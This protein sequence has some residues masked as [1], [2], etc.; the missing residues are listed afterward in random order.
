MKARKLTRNRWIIYLLVVMLTVSSINLLPYSMAFA[1]G[2]NESPPESQTT[3]QIEENRV[4]IPTLRTETAK[5]FGNPDGTYTAEVMAKPI[6]FKKGD[7]WEEISNT[8]VPTPDGSEIENKQNKFKVKFPKNIKTPGYTKLFTYEISGR[9]IAFGFNDTPKNEK[10]KV[11]TDKQ[12][13]TINNTKHSVLYKNV[14]K[15][16]S[17]EYKVDGSKVK[18]NII[19]NSYQGKNSFEFYIKAK[20]IKAEKKENGQIVFSDETTGEFLFFIERPF[21]FDS[22]GENSS[23]GAVSQNVS[24]DISTADGGFILT[25]VADDS[26]L[27]DPK[28]VYPVTIDP[29]VDVFQAEDTWIASGTNYNNHYTDYLFIGNHTEFGKTRSLLKWVL[30]TIPNAEV[31]DAQIGLSQY[32]SKGETAVNLHRITSSYDTTKV[33]WATQPSYSPALESSMSIF[34]SNGW[35]EYV[36]ATNLVKGWY[37][38]SFPNYGVLMK[39]GDSQEGTV[40]RKE[41]RATEWINPDG[42]N[43]ENPKLVITYRPKELLGM[44]DYWKYTPDLFEGEGTAVVNVINGNMVYDIGLLSLTSKSNSFDLELVYNSR[45]NYQDSFGYGWSFSDQRRLIIPA[46]KKIVE[47]IDENG[48][49]YHFNKHQDDD[50]TSYSAPEGVYLEFTSTNDGGYTIKQTDETILTFDSLGRNMKITDEKGNNTIYGF[51]GNSNRVVKISERFGTQP[52]GRDLSLSYNS[53]GLL[54]RVTDLIGTETSLAYQDYNGVKRLESITY[55]SNR[56]EKKTV[57]F[58][59]SASHQLTAITDGNGNKGKIEYDSA[60][61]VQKIIDPRPEAYFAQLSYPSATETIFT[62]AKQNQTYFKYAQS[63]TGAT[64]NVVEMK[65]NYKTADES[66]TKYEWT[67]NTVTKVIEPNPST[68]QADE[69]F[70]NTATYDNKGNVTG[71]QSPNNISSETTYDSKSNVTSDKSLGTVFEYVYDSKSNLVSSWDNYK[72]AD[73]NTHDLFGNVATSVSG[74][75]NTYNRLQNSNFERLD[76]T[77]QASA[78]SRRSLGQYSSS[79]DHVYGKSSAQITLSSSDGAGYYTQTVPVQSDELDKSYSYSAYMKTSNVTGEGAQ[80]RIYPLD[81]NQQY[82][83]DSSGQVIKYHSQALKGTNDWIRISDFVTLPAGTVNVKVDLLVTGTGTVKFD[84]VQLLYG[85]TLDQFYSNEYSSMEW[86]L[87]TTT[88]YTKLFKLGI[89]D[90]QTTERARRGSYSYKLNGVSNEARYFGQYA[91]VQGKAGEPLTLS[92]WVYTQNPNK[93]GLLELRLWIM[94]TDGKEEGFIIPFDQ[95]IVD[96]WQFV[97]KTVRANKDFSRAKIYGLY[98][99]QTGKA[100]FDNLKLEENSSTASDV[101]S[102]DG[103]FTEQS[104]NELNNVSSFGYDGN[105]NQTTSINE[106]G[107]K[108]KFDYDYL[109]RLKATTLVK[110][111]DTDPE[112]IK[113]SYDYDTQGNLKT[114]TEPRGYQTTFDYN[115]INMVTRET[116]P[117]NKFIRYEYDANGNLSLIERGKVVNSVDTV[118]TKIENQ[119]DSKDRLKEKYVGGQPKYSYS[120]DRAD[121]L[122][123]LNSPDGT[124]SFEYDANKRLTKSTNPSGYTLNNHYLDNVSSPQHG[125]RDWYS[126]SFNNVT[127]KTEYTFDILKRLTSVKNAKG[128]VTDFYYDESHQPVRIK[129]GATNTYLAYDETG[130]VTQQTVFGNK[131]LNLKH[132]YFKDGNLKTISTGPKTESFTYDFAGRAETWNNGTSTTTYRYDKSGN[133]LNPKGKNLT[134]NGANEVIGFT[135]DDAGNLSKDDKYNY[136][137]DQ[138]GRLLRVTNLSGSELASYTYHPDGLRKT[139]KV[140]ASTYHYHYDG[141]NLIRITD[142]SNAT[143]WTI[144]WANGKPVSFTNKAGNTYFYITNYRGDVIQIVDQNG[145]ETA[146][147]S[148]DP[149]GNVLSTAENAEVTGQPLGYASYVYDRETKLY[150]LQARYYDPET[151]RFISRDPDPGDSDDPKSQNGYTYADN[152]PVMLVDPDGNSSIAAGGIYLTFGG[153]NFWNP[154]GWT[155]LGIAATVSVGYLV[156]RFAKA[157]DGISEHTSNARGS[158][159][160]KHQQGQK[161]KLK[162]NGG[163]KGDKKR[164][165][166]TDKKKRNQDK[167]K[168]KKKKN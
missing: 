149:W 10:L 102:S 147:Y 79:T 27:A 161:R 30:P 1:E 28:R 54:E 56:P 52:T 112:N 92:G 35:Y 130:K 46:D 76:P 77:G 108:T 120:Y 69:G 80:L 124:Y 106:E 103:N 168:K 151:A 36:N 110:G 145:L 153:A 150:Y 100:Y 45:S 8:L 123:T 152:N 90:G 164:T 64:V 67:K 160:N 12:D 38:G 83:Y 88:D 47:Y 31:V 126:E 127:E 44:T 70:S 117:L 85:A 95:S 139:K 32:D 4:E 167:N 65:E 165:P 75:R 162:D 62:D 129:S 94:Y 18:E 158:T 111:S 33:T 14:F 119:Y 20:G 81:A 144:T 89:Y 71:T 29:W 51:D 166:R 24:Q 101:Y 25:V 121:N 23:E 41:F 128:A 98:E 131:T 99:N 155:V 116:D 132:T 142:Q 141:S 78:W 16:V 137:W 58:G 5:V 125:L 143:L 22:S 40:G 146:N 13:S 157:G 57:T 104:T 6:H 122:K 66:T 59:Y 118:Q 68:G 42:S 96:K 135:Y 43:I 74:T 2:E 37:A 49:R 61:R 97:K 114:R 15:D 11:H 55:A 163:E 93:T 136:E 138:E 113:I 84:G 53:S 109:N 63:S 72:I 107:R 34:T 159:K 87:D 7:K 91:E 82:L 21:M 60:N 50:T 19:L 115:A 9:Q 140:G 134:F 148:Y 105:G 17:F 86:N 26:Y 39:Y 3:E 73:F 154:V 133:L 156:Y 48:T